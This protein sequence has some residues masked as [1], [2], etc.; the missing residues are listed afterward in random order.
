MP[1]SILIGLLV[2]VVFVGMFLLVWSRF[3]NLQQ[4]KDAEIAEM[5]ARRAPTPEE[6]FNNEVLA[7]LARAT[8]RH[9]HWS[10][11]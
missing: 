7:A 2:Y 1:G 6:V 11:R 3:H 5:L 8:P 9:M 10:E 4:R